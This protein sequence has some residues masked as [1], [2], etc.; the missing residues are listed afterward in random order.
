MEPEGNPEISNNK[1]QTVEGTKGGGR[2][3][4]EAGRIWKP[5]RTQTVKAGT[6]EMQSLLEEILEEEREK[7]LWPPPFLYL[8][9]SHGDSI[10][11]T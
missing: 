10:G 11:Q 7:I 3:S 5:W 8:P 4:Q 1:Q 6:L 9:A 2:V